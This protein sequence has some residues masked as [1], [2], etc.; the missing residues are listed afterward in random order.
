M[1]LGR[2]EE[3]G[4]EFGWPLRRLKGK[5][6]RWI[7]DGLSARRKG[8]STFCVEYDKSQA[9]IWWGWRRITTTSKSIACWILDHQDAGSKVSKGA[10]CSSSWQIL[11]SYITRP[12]I[13]YVKYGIFSSWGTF[14]SSVR[15]FLALWVQKLR[16]S[17]VLSGPLRSSQVIF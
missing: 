2:N 9:C 7:I 8:L 1:S 13:K 6:W 3:V 10:L 17:Q 16:T 12:W 11:R 14:C 15:P 4:G 5:R